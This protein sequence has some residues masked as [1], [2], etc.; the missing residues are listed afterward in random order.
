MEGKMFYSLSEAI[1]NGEKKRHELSF[2]CVA[3]VSSFSI[4]R[5]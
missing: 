2:L 3:S 1:F 5:W 4:L